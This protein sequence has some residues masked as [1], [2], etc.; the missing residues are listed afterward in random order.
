MKGITA[1]GCKTWYQITQLN[2]EN[3]KIKP[4]G[5]SRLLKSDP[6]LVCRSQIALKHDISF[7]AVYSKNNA[8][9]KENLK[10]KSTLYVLFTSLLQSL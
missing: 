9:P 3:Q 2:G 8:K 4:P 10:R 5:Q 7:V 6:Y 1:L